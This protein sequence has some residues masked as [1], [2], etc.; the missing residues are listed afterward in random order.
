MDDDADEVEQ[1]EQ[2]GDYISD[3]MDDS[4]GYDVIKQHEWERCQACGVSVAC[5]SGWFANRVFNGDTVIQRIQRGCPYPLGDF[6]CARCNDYANSHIKDS[7]VV[8]ET[9][10]GDKEWWVDFG[11]YP[12]TADTREEA[13]DKAEWLRRRGDYDPAMTIVEG[14]NDD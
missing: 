1:Q 7:G 13:I 11:S 5:G 6:I 8:D 3:A 10:E 12:L 2:L 9:E 14:N 4:Y